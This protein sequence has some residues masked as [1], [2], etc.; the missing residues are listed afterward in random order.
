[1]TYRSWEKKFLR[2]QDPTPLIYKMNMKTDLET[3]YM[4]IVLS[5][6]IAKLCAFNANT[7]HKLLLSNV[8]FVTLAFIL[9]LDSSLSLK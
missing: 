4:L 3:E 5:Q 1:M 2:K 6:G 7:Y 8:F 9:H